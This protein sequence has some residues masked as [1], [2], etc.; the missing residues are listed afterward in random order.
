MKLAEALNMRADLQRRAVQLEERLL[1]N[2]KYQEGDS[3]SED[4]QDLLKE[5]D[6]I[7]E[8]LMYYICHINRTNSN[9]LDGDTSLTDMLGRKDVLSQKLSILRK[10]IKEASEKC[11][12]YGNREIRLLST[13]NVSDMQKESDRLSRE[14]RELD[15]RIQGL[16]WTTE[17][18]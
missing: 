1:N 3:P 11:D 10:F 12:R 15:T 16:N 9:T 17:L 4:P 18:V 7:T 8:Q 6:S 5:L 2:A 14:L 13:V